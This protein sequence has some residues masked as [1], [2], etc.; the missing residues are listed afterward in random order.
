MLGCNELKKLSLSGM[1]IQ[2]TTP[3]GKEV[4]LTYSLTHALRYIVF[5]YFIHPG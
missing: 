2:G 1:P 3:D 4:T 5:I